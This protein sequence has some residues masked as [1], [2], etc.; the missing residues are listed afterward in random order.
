M[1]ARLQAL[2]SLMDPTFLAALEATGQPAREHGDEHD[3]ATGALRLM[4][5]PLV[6]PFER[7][8]QQLRNDLVKPY[9]L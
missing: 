5:F 7:N 3:E 1:G 8:G 2:R 6:G 4:R 9:L